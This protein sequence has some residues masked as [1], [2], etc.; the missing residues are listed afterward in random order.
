MVLK[1]LLIIIFILLSL[2]AGAVA[3]LLSR[4]TEKSFPS[5]AFFPAP[6][7][8]K[9]LEDPNRINAV[10]RNKIAEE[11]ERYDDP[12]YDHFIESAAIIIDET[13]RLGLSVS[14]YSF[15]LRNE[16]P[17]LEIIF[18]GLPAQVMPFLMILESAEPILDVSRA[19]FTVLDKRLSVT[20]TI[21]PAR[22]NKEEI[23]EYDS[24]IQI[25]TAIGKSIGFE[26]N[27]V[28]KTPDALAAAAEILFGPTFRNA[29]PQSSPRPL[30][31]PE[32]E[33]ASFPE[34]DTPAIPICIVGRYIEGSGGY[35]YAMK[36]G[37]TGRIRRLRVGEER[38]GWRLL[39][40]DDG[41]LII[42]IEEKTHVVP[43]E[44]CS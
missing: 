29:S 41:L 39:S 30:E 16:I 32:P 34:S 1:R 44:E 8:K 18:S 6:A 17:T 24:S 10:L 31:P 28:A 40:D 23:G 21:L 26:K 7:E 33:E 4:N 37:R 13:D 2:G 25:D 15:F 11:R 5:A 12:P 22:C 43:R 19:S 9:R 38:S 36:D 3:A 14:S 20:L 42:R 27:L 35:I